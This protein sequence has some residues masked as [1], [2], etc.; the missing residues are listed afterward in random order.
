M[1]YVSYLGK[2]PLDELVALYQAATLVITASLYESSSLPA[3]EAAAAGTPIIASRIPPHEEHREVLQLSLFS[4]LDDLELAQLILRVWQD[5]AL[6][7]TQ[8][9]ANRRNVQ[10]YCWGNAGRRYLACFSRLL[11]S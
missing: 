9:A 7:Q 1:E 4:P 2:V 11:E 10:H 8:A 5:A 3:L 6:R